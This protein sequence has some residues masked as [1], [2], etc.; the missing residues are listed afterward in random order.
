MAENGVQHRLTVI[1][2]ADVV[3]YARLTEADEAGTRAALNAHRHELI[4]GKLAEHHGRLVSTAGDSLL[5][6]FQSVVE[7]VTCAVEVQRA[8][9]ERNVDI[10]ENRRIIFRIGINLG[11][12][13][14]EGEDIHGDGVNVAAR[15]QALAE[16]GGI[17]VSGKVFEET[18][19]RLDAT[20]EDLGEQTVKNIAR[21]I[22]AYAVRESRQ[23]PDRLGGD[24]DALALPS[25]PSIAVLPFDNMSGDPEQAY[26]ADGIADDIITG[27]SRFRDLFVIARNSSFTYKGGAVDINHVG[28]E[29][30]VRYVLEGGVRKAGN[31]VRIT[32]QLVEAES[33]S[34]LWAEKY[35]GNLAD[36][37][38]LQD[39]ITASVVGAIQS[40]VTTAEM[41]RAR[42]KRPE[43][44][45]AYEW[46][47]KGWSHEVQFDR[48]NIFEAKKCFLKAIELDARLARAHT[49]L[50]H[51]FFWE[52][53]LGWSESYEKAM[54]EA[55][56]HM[57]T[58]V[59]IDPSDAE[60][61]TWLSTVFLIAHNLDAALA[62]I[63]L[64]VELSPN[65]AHA[66]GMR[67][68]VYCYSGRPQEGVDEA[69]LA[70][71]LSP[72]DDFR[73]MFLHEL[74][75]CQNTV[76]DFAGAAQTATQM[77]TLRPDY[78]YGHFHLAISRAQLGQ[79]ARAQTAVNEMMRLNPNIDYAF[80]DSVAPYKDS[81]DLK[82]L[83]EGLRK[84]GW[85]G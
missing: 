26:F 55:K 30:G 64:A 4:D 1:V 52:A 43:N 54:A 44:L 8:M 50:A 13:I 41:E 59:T 33:G 39:E 19:H 47:M 48:T 24:S 16:P 25:K 84:A 45:D 11:E 68:A 36:I 15:L 14:V 49:G 27:L 80:V 69:K 18:R 71:R 9:T 56:S 63:E 57:Q 46:C 6:E 76:G 66:R 78:L 85:K 83:V 23:K 32:A 65:Y 62:E 10:P 38:D 79:P 20:F 70:L 3:G 21:P 5:V 72:R 17:C 51:S 82:T 42:R 22:T 81:D 58:A 53:A 12:V 34:H 74:V 40:S 31:R 60:A 75:Q 73:F 67:A 7:A 37:F 61:H 29:L 2:S 77:V 28:R 35:D